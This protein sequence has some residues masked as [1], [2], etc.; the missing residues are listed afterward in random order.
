M[1]KPAHRQI[2]Q[3][4]PLLESYRFD[5]G[6]EDWPAEHGGGVR[7][8]GSVYS[9]SRLREPL[10]ELNLECLQQ[11][12]APVRS[13][14][15]G[16]DARPAAFADLLRDAWVGLSPR[17]LERIA[18]APFALLAGEFAEAERWLAEPTA[19][20]RDAG[21][22]RERSRSV[23]CFEPAVGSALLRRLLIYGWY[24]ART[25]P[26]TA[27]LV[28]GTGAN[29][30]AMLADS[31]LTA[32]ETLADVRGRSLQLRWPDHPDYWLR[33]LAAASHDDGANRLQELLLVGVRRLVGQSVGLATRSLR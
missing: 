3:Q 32:L 17:G 16:A 11:L 9:A 31:S 24:L 27:R 5:T 2:E 13:R 12:V 22:E 1:N 8:Q 14:Q 25:R 10:V 23:L 21:P 33:L 29:A 30:V 7:E 20:V 28:L 18:V 15:G 6:A 26:R 4:L 19:G